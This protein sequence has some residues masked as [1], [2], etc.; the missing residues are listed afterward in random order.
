MENVVVI[1]YL[2]ILDQIFFDSIHGQ[3]V[4]L[5][6]SVVTTQDDTVVAQLHTEFQELGC[7]CSVLRQQ[8]L[9]A[10]SAKTQTTLVLYCPNHLHFP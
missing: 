8:L 3:L 4:F 5:K 1:Q 7:F 2:K 9:K 10:F 6:Q